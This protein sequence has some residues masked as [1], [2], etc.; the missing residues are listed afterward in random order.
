MWRRVGGG[1]SC[2][3]RTT[4]SAP[5]GSPSE[6]HSPAQTS[7]CRCAAFP[8]LRGHTLGCLS[9]SHLELGLRTNPCQILIARYV[10]FPP[11]EAASGFTGFVTFPPLGDLFFPLF[12][13]QF[14]RM[15]LEAAVCA[16]SLLLCAPSWLPRP[17]NIYRLS[18]MLEEKGNPTLYRHRLGCCC[19][20]Q[21]LPKE[22][23]HLQCHRVLRAGIEIPS[24]LKVVG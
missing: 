20:L 4:T 23:C 15:A 1:W 13:A 17:A 5:A 6:T 2:L 19:M 11:L 16:R 14:G 7:M 21:S 24:I 3:G 9:L 12:N 18:C 10:A 8:P 22:K